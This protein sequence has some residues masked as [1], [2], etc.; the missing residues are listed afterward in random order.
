MLNSQLGDNQLKI[1]IFLLLFIACF[2][3]GGA[4]V[5]YWGATLELD[6]SAQKKQETSKKPLQK[7]SRSYVCALGRL[8][9]KGEVLEVGS[10]GGNRLESLLVKEGDNVKK[11]QILGY[12]D[13]YKEYLAEKNYV[14]ALL[15]EAKEKLQTNT[16]YWKSF[17]KK[18]QI[19]ITKIEKTM[20]F[21]IQA[22]QEELKSYRV[23]LAHVQSELN[24][25]E[26][27]KSATATEQSLDQYKSLVKEYSANYQQ[28][29]NKL[30]E[31]KLSQRMDLMIAKMEL[32]LAHR[33]LEQAKQEIALESLKRRIEVIQAKLEQAIVYA[34]ANGCILRILIRAGEKLEGLPILK[35]GDT[36]HMYAIAE[37]YET[38]IRF[39]KPGQK[40]VISSMALVT[41]I[42]GSVEHIG[43]LIFKNKVL[44]VNPVSD[45]DIRVVEVK[46]RLEQSKQIEKLTNLQVN[47][48]I[49][50]Q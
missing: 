33:S 43:L 48:K 40:A 45:V 23:K 28:V 44:D 7:Q 25:L 36:R 24:R 4:A 35:M 30:Q 31:L 26:R 19:N 39:V 2:I 41:P 16:L 50:T 11:G 14:K 18:V 9:P 3:G 15:T 37:V 47:V 49:K 20:P 5:H 10:T 38:D 29:L 13:T 21:A 32:G 46:I 1:I 6:F 8:E 34:P 27:L 17:I 42:K 12:L 22:M